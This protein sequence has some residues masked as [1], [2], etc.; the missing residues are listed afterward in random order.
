MTI[1]GSGAFSF[2]GWEEATYSEASEGSKLA[3]AKVT[4]DF[5]GAIE[6]SGRLTYVLTYLPGG[7][8]VFTGYEQIVGSVGGRS[9][10]FVLFHDGRVANAS[11][12]TEFVVTTSLMV[13]P[14]SGSGALAQLTG[15]GSFTGRHEDTET[16]YSFDYEIG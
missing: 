4:N 7:E 14:G 6:G 16:H 2:T 9:G 15:S 10:S 13:V 11:S 8:A 1:H 12:P 3:T 5:H